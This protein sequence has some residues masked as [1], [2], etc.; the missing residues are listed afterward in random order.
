MF[1]VGRPKKEDGSRKTRWRRRC[2]TLVTNE[3]VFFLAARTLGMQMHPATVRCLH[4]TGNCLN[5]DLFD[6]YDFGEYH[7]HTQRIASLLQLS[8]VSFLIGTPV[9]Q[10]ANRRSL[11]GKLSYCRTSSDFELPSS[12]SLHFL[13]G[14]PDHRMAD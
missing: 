7:W 4:E 6:Y 11:I 10:L 13:I 3:N 2:Q 12:V 5:C 1:K 8:V 9:R 14:T